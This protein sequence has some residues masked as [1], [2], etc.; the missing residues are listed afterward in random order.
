[1]KPCEDTHLVKSNTKLNEVSH[2]PKSGWA[3]GRF[4]SDPQHLQ[5][6]F[7]NLSV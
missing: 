6:T 4:T 3:F 5:I 7:I 1:M 2:C